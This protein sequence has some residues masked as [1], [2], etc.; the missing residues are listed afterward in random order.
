MNTV[1]QIEKRTSVKLYYGVQNVEATPIQQELENWKNNFPNL[2]IRVVY[3]DDGAGYIQDILQ[4]EVEELDTPSQSGVILCGQRD[5]C[6]RIT[7]YMTQLGVDPD[8][9]LLNF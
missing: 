7:D 8:C 3:S 5:M 1:C 9:I 4:K 2:H 6:E